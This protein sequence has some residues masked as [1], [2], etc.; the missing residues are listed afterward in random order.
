MSG[1]SDA[2]DQ[3]AQ[4]PVREEKGTNA[5]ML[6][7]TYCPAT[8]EQPRPEGQFVYRSVKYLPV[9]VLN[10]VSDVRVSYAYRY[11]KGERQRQRELGIVVLDRGT[12]RAA[13]GQVNG[14][15]GRRLI[16]KYGSSKGIRSEL[17][18]RL[19]GK[20]F[21]AQDGPAL[22]DSLLVDSATRSDP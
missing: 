5:E 9:G 21:N 1:Q 4:E 17:Y 7:D 18:R 3:P 22:V 10:R 14:V 12:Q 6:W 2:P 13:H 16:A 19:V 20:P 15:R 11:F 8:L